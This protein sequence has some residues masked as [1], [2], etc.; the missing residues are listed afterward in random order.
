MKFEEKVK[1]LEKYISELE[2]DDIDL[3]S[4]IKNYTEAMNLVKECDQELKNAEEKITKIVKENN[5]EDF[6]LSE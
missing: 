2:N 6:K 1:K 3:D 5:L 4:A